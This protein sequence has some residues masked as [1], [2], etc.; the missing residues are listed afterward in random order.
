MTKIELLPEEQ[1]SAATQELYAL[2]KKKMG[3]VP[4]IY[5]VYGHSAAALQANLQLDEA[6]SKGEL[7]GKEIEMV[8]LVVSQ[9]N[10]CDYCLAAHTMLAKMYGMTDAQALQVRAGAFE[11]SEKWQ[12]LLNFTQA[13]LRKRGRI[14]AEELQDFLEAGYT[15]GA[16]VEV[17]G[18]IAKNMFNNYANHIA[19][20]EVDF[21][22]APALLAVA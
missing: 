15:R 14:A 2:L 16:V 3:K 17:I 11:G 10:E 5:Q 4:N 8:A 21:P 22:K 18:Q 9:F 13:V 1:A 12:A 19:G 7:S 6:L 20:T